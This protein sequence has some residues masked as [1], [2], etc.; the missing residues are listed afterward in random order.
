M[1]LSIW[2]NIWKIK[3][4][5]DIFC[6]LFKLKWLWWSSWI[7]VILFMSVYWFFWEFHSNLSSDSWNVFIANR[8]QIHFHLYLVTDDNYIFG[9]V[10]TFNRLSK[11]VFF[12]AGRR[13]CSG[14]A[15]WPEI[16]HWLFRGHVWCYFWADGLVE[17]KL[18]PSKVMY[19]P[20]II[21][22]ILKTVISR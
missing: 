14:A 18:K 6:V 16:H 1:Y 20:V 4:F 12:F 8:Q 11:C 15:S 17:L 7:R 21:K 19:F 9:R 5:L 10:T 3:Q 22:S 2:K 13:Q